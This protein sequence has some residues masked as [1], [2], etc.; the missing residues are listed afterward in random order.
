MDDLKVYFCDLCNTSI[1]EQDIGEGRAKQLHGKTVGAC[2]LGELGQAAPA[3]AAAKTA[4]PGAQSAGGGVVASTIVVLVAIAGATLFLD[5]RHADEAKVA[6]DAVTSVR[7]QIRPLSDQLLRL[8]QRMDTTL[9]GDALAPVQTRLEAVATEVGGIEARV[10]QAVRD[11]AT[12]LRD[13]AT[14]IGSLESGQRDH[15]ARIA[16]LQSEMRRTGERVDEWIA[17]GARVAAPTIDP[18]ADSGAGAGAVPTDAA[19]PGAGLPE[20]L[21]AF[22]AQLTDADDG[23]RFEAVDELLQ[24]GDARVYGH[25]LPLAADPDPFV[26]RLVF[27]GL[28]DHRDPV[29]VDALIK[30]LG[31]T[32]SL[33]RYTAHASL[34][35]LTEQDFAFDPDAAS[36]KRASMQR[37][38]QEWWDKNRD[39]LFKS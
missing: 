17:A 5:S 18:P 15:V 8:E 6:Q 30:A 24:S 26:R 3:A 1:P 12:R 23:E 27:E 38:W 37:R 32:E 2:C 25:I 21:Q 4:A 29:S 20:H 39:T 33:V 11:N 34:K 19:G 9:K 13:L 22:V 28:K 16:E 14:Q 10:V 7:D 31:D 35:A 36:G